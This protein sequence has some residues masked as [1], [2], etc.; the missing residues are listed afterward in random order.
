MRPILIQVH[1]FIQDILGLSQEFTVEKLY[2]NTIFLFL[3]ILQE[4]VSHSWIL[5]MMNVIC[6]YFFHVEWEWRRHL[7]TFGSRRC[8]THIW[9][10]LLM[11]KVISKSPNTDP[12]GTPTVIAEPLTCYC[13]ET[14][15]GSFILEE[16]IIHLVKGPS[17]V[18]KHGRGTGTVVTFSANIQAAVSVECRAWRLK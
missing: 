15:K 12:C 18:Q 5:H 17:Q 13:R 9:L 10:L 14:N 1:L 11:Y 6:Q 2:I 16:L 4:A 7:C 8:Y 3:H